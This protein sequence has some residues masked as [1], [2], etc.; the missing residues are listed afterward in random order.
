MLPPQAKDLEAAILGIVMMEPGT[1]DTVT[2]IL[3]PEAFYMEGHQ[4]IYRAILNLTNKSRPTDLLM[5]TEE[6]TVA[7]ELDVVGG[8]YYVSKLTNDVR[9]SAPLEEYCRIVQQKFI[10]R[11][12]IRIGAEIHA[13]GFDQSSDVFDLLDAAE[14]KIM[15]I[16]NAIQNDSKSMDSVLVKTMAQ[17]AEWRKLDTNIT[18]VPSGFPKLDRVTRGWQPGDLVILAARPSVGKTAMALALARA[19]AKND[20]R[21]VPV[22]IWSLEMDSMQLALRMLSAESGTLLHRLQTGRLDDAQ[23][24][25]L[26][27]DGV[28]RLAAMKI[29]FDDAPGLNLFTLRS[30]ARRL[31]RKHGIGLI[32]IDYL[33]LMSGTGSSR[34]QEIS[35]I[36]RGLKNL[37]KEL[38]IPIIALSQL[39]RELEKR[40]GKKRIPQL[41]DLRE[42]GAIEQD[43]D[44]VIFL[45]GPE[46]DE[47]EKD[48]SLATRRYAKRAKARSGMLTTIT[49]D[50][51]GEIQMFKEAPD[52]PKQVPMGLPPGN[53]KPV[54]NLFEKDSE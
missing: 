47:I 41:S 37:A 31:K 8:A 9:S 29:F 26:H 36:S 11:E 53:F 39:S 46:E 2:M 34:E 50:F 21:S 43:A 12:M 6:L 49:L 22:A 38:Q 48:A 45:W 19:A 42:S 16:G 3:K 23:M 28:N 15:G 24:A 33:Q 13:A 27:K 17:I 10:Q 44:D 20:I 54:S 7:G 5:V 51:H 25:L 52:E 18:G 30:K 4:R 14:Q 35:S 1:I 40:T 32:V